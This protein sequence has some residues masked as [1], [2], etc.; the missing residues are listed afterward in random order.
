MPKSKRE[1]VFFSIVMSIVMVYGMEL[2]NLAIESGGLSN[3]LF[4][5][6]FQDLPMMCV[7]VL[8]LESC[9]AG[10]IARKI[11]FQLFSAEADKQI[12]ITLCIA[13]L[14]VSMMCPMMSAVATLI[15]KQ[16]GWQFFS[17]WIQT[18]ALNFPMAFFWQMFFAGPFV[19]AV[20]RACFRIQ[21]TKV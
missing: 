9:I 5:K 20:Y 2:Y 7:F 3:E 12:F 19:R 6:V 15:F 21:T 18:A 4:L 11:T 10:P 14:T 17:I 13:V 8:I 1:K 16:P